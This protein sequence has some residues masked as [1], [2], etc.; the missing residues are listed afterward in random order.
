MS[1]TAPQRRM[2]EIVRDA[3]DK[4]RTIMPRT[5]ARRM[6]PDSPAWLRHT[7]AGPKGVALAG[8]MPMNAAVILWRL[9]AK[10]LVT[11]SGEYGNLWS[12][13]DEGR[14]ELEKSLA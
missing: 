7:K 12:V 9:Q 5:A 13:T 8:T 10:G 4:H 6:W 2:L 1:L 11:V 3:T 14:K